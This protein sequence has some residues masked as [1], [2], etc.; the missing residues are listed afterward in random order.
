VKVLSESLK[1]NSTLTYL[2]VHPETDVS[3]EFGEYLS[4]N[5]QL[6]S[7]S[8]PDE[9]ISFLNE[10]YLS[11]I[12]IRSK[13]GEQ[14]RAHRIVLAAMSRFAFISYYVLCDPL[15]LL[16][17]VC[18]PQIHAI[19]TQPLFC[20]RLFRD[21]LVEKSSQK[22]AGADTLTEIDVDIPSE[23]LHTLVRG[24]L[25]NLFCVVSPLSLISPSSLILLTKKLHYLYSGVVNITCMK[26]S[27]QRQEFVRSVRKLIPEHEDR[28]TELVKAALLTG[29][30]TTESLRYS[31]K[32]LWA[33]NNPLFHDVV[34]VVGDGDGDS[35]KNVGRIPAHKVVLC[36]RSPY[37]KALLTGGMKVCL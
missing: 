33:F 25:Y 23:Y 27:D 24:T 10:E 6:R 9:M 2:E 22:T 31:R 12:I 8:V 30:E 5:K 15:S 35:E 20:C 32:M 34:F 36:A 19:P 3:I 29:S 13:N 21:L 16:Y 17:F 7:T 11:D 26:T 14:V 18:S 37:F 4:R 28:M 1:V